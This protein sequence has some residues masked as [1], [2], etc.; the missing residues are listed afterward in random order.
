MEL[1]RSKIPVK[2]LLVA[3]NQEKGCFSCKTKKKLKRVKNIS[4][5]AQL[6]LIFLLK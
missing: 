6:V 5:P 3:L 4:N 1:S 2:V